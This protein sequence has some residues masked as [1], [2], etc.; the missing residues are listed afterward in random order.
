MGRLPGAKTRGLLFAV[1]AAL[2]I[3]DLS[4][5]GSNRGPIPEMPGCY[6]FI[7]RH[8]PKATLLEI[9]YDPVG[10]DLNS[11]CT[12]WQASHRLTTSAGYSG[13]DNSLLETRIG[14]D[15]PVT[16]AKMALPDYLADPTRMSTEFGPDVDFRSYLWIYLT[17][18]GF[19]YVVLHTQHNG[20][21][22]GSPGLARLKRFWTIARCSRTPAASFMHVLA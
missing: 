21:P 15:S 3:A 1:L 16:T 12:Y 11:L 13:H 20:L 17:A 10:T 5:P 22:D 18:N 7:R 19:D 14:Q 9:P 6:A 8:N 4:Y 2:A